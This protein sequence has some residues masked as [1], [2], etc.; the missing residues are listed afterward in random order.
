MVYDVDMYPAI[1]CDPMIE[2]IMPN[3]NATLNAN[4]LSSKVYHL[5]RSGASDSSTPAPWKVTVQKKTKQYDN[6]TNLT[7]YVVCSQP[8]IPGPA[9]A[10]C[11]VQKRATT[12]QNSAYYLK[13]QEGTVE[14]SLSNL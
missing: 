5:R 13:K 2:F 4:M 6:F 14:N 1:K 8:D 11:C 9:Q 10:G 7:K 12:I 3:L